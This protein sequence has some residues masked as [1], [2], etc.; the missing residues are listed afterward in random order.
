MSNLPQQNNIFLLKGYFVQYDKFDRAKLQFLDNY[1][2][3]DMKE[4]SF[5]K[6]FI[7]NKSKRSY[8]HNPTDGESYFFIKCSKGMYGLIDI[9]PNERAKLVPIE[10]LVQ[11]QVECIVKLSNYDFIL[12]GENKKGWNFKMMKIKLLKF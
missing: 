6:S 12:N 4:M 11:H 5:T 10:E 8:G 1:E 3:T 7:I 2:C 9:I